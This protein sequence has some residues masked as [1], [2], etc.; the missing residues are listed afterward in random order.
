MASAMFWPCET[1]TSTCR[2]FATISSGVYLFLGIS[3]LLHVKRH[4]S[5][6]TTF[7]GEDHD[8]PRK[9]QPAR[10]KIRKHQNQ[11]ERR[12]EEQVG[13]QRDLHLESAQQRFELEYK[14]G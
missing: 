11:D 13:E 12:A 6:R 7:Q 3:V 9:S 8:V 2:N 5:R 10:D 14:V 4:S 1:R